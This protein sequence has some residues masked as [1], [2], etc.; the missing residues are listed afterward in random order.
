MHALTRTADS[1]RICVTKWIISNATTSDH[2]TGSG[3]CPRSRFGHMT[4]A[5]LRPA[6]GRGGQISRITGGPGL[7]KDGPALGS[8]MVGTGHSNVSEPS[9]SK[10]PA[11]FLTL[12][13]H[14]QRR[15]LKP[16]NAK[17]PTTIPKPLINV[18]RIQLLGHDYHQRRNIRIRC[19]IPSHNVSLI[20][21]Q[22][23]VAARAIIP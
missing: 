9:I 13:S 12:G 14:L 1:S 6:A 17:L 15:S 7:E 8:K 3:I 10:W 4:G 19:A 21:T 23:L 22:A 11:S 16:S 20:G 18:A 5:G 2:M